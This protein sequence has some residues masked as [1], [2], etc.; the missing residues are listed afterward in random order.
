MDVVPLGGRAEPRV[1]HVV[2]ARHALDHVAAQVGVDAVGG[3][4]QR[5]ARAQDQVVHAGQGEERG[6]VVRAV[7]LPQAREQGGDDVGCQCV[8]LPTT[9]V[10]GEVGLRGG[11][12]EEEEEVG[13]VL[14]G[15][16]VGL[17]D[18][19]G[20]LAEGAVGPVGGGVGGHEGLERGQLEERLD[21][22]EGPEAGE[23]LEGGQGDGD[24]GLVVG[25]G[26]VV[27]V[28]G[29]ER[30]GEVLVLVGVD[31]QRQGLGDGQDLGQE[32]QLA[33]ELLNDLFA[34]EHLL[35]L[36]QHVL[37]QLA[38]LQHAGRVPRYLNLSRGSRRTT[39][40]SST[41]RP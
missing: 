3:Y 39:S 26:E 5:L 37:E 2:A 30:C 11:E 38:R 32:G 33:A 13:G 28:L 8:V 9:T 7:L 17:E 21:L 27:R 41:H 34:Q 24:F 29:V 1:E 4:V 25:V 16:G 12:E 23:E 22:G 40:R 6:R 36:V 20:D 35:V 14:D 18:V 15:A 10:M 19:A 31:L